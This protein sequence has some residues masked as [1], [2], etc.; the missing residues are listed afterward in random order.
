MTVFKTAPLLI[1]ALAAS[2]C[3][4]GGSGAA[5]DYDFNVRPSY[6]NDLRQASYDGAGNDLLTGGLGRSG[7]QDDSPPGYA[8]SQPTAEELRRNAIYVNYRALVDTTSEGGYGRLYG[9]NVDAQGRAT[10]G[11]GMVAGT[12]A[13]AYSDDGSGRRN[14][15]LMVQVPDAFDRTRP[16]IIT[17]TSSGSRGIY[18]GIPTGEWGLKRGCA[19][20]YTDKGT[21]AAPHDL[22]AD[23][24]ALIDGTRTSATLAGTRAAFDAGLS[25]ADLAAFNGATPQ[26]LAFKHAHSGQNPEKDWGLSTLQAVEFAFYVL[27]ERF[28]DRSPG[29]QALRTFTP[30]N[31]TVIASSLSNGG[32]AAIAA[33]EQDTRG[34]IDGVAVSEPSV[35]MPANAGVTVQRGGRTVA[36]NGLPLIDYTTQAHLYQACAAL[37][38]SLASTPF[39]AAFAV[40]FA[41]PA[42]PVA[43]NRCA[44]LKA[45]GLLSAATTAAQA[46][47]ALARLTAYGWEPESGALHASLAAFEVAPSIAVTYANALSRASVQDR[48]CGYS[49][50]T[51]SAIG[52]VQPTP[53]AVT[54]TLFAT[55]NGIP[56]TAGVQLVNDRSRGVPVRD[57]FSSNA[58]GVPTW[59][60]EG[61][62]CLRSLVTGTDAAA[63]RLQ[64]GLD[65]TRRTGNL[66][67]KPAI[68]VHGRDDALIPVN[69]TSRPY[70]A[71]N[72][73]VEGAASRLSYIEVTNAQHFDA[74]IGLPATLPGYDSRYIP[75]HLY[76]NRALDAMYAHLVNGEPLPAS[77]VVRTV[78]RGGTPGSAPAITAANVPPIA[79]MPVAADAVA[80]TSGAIA[81]PD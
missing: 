39:A 23:T 4:G 33:A 52:A 60:L 64:S 48:L 49:F 35:Q 43:A 70:A 54:N 78:P 19:V 41:D 36:V 21:G 24:V 2:S 51:T 6:L 56:P 80:I 81:V 7:L 63:R 10:S 61:A 29:G 13:I 38:P 9:P 50:A 5:V 11:E 59:N 34:L 66:Q 65:E 31:T 16:C 27:N 53:A 47:E 77:Q 18:G 62:L 73:R 57:L 75:L 14:V 76:L 68:I 15:T 22:Q 37:A 12:E 71:L 28:G 72:R 74:F 30:A 25:A 44:G 42:F 46:E 45:R 3:G 67:G 40:R 20:A 79:A 69:H 17:A 32:G 58:A 26:R 55:G 8:G 1:A